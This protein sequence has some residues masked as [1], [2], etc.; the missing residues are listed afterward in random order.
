MEHRARVLAEFDRQHGIPEGVSIVAVEI[1]FWNLV[2][3]VLKVYFA[4]V[5]AS[6]IIGAIGGLLFLVVAYIAES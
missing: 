2:N 4:F 3:L 1:P 6:A 5:V